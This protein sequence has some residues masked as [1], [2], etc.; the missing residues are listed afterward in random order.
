MA[1]DDFEI[2][3]GKSLGDLGKEALWFLF[4]S[5]IA[6]TTMVVTIL[7]M[8]A[9]I[10]SQGEAG[11]IELGTVLVCLVPFLVGYIIVKASGNEIAQYVWITGLLLFA[12]VCV[13]VLDLPTGNG[14]CEHCGPV[15][16]LWRTFFSVSNGSGLMAGQGIMV[17]A[18]AP[19]ALVGYAIGANL[20]LKKDSE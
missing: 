7:A 5:A 4:H 13:W 12:A 9:L 1:T 20:G 11:P 2:S 6:L 15:E 14:L 8:S 18:W 3:P 10:H 17:G 16:K 19:L